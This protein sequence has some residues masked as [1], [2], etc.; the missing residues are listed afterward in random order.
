MNDNQYASNDQYNPD[1]QYASN[2]QYN[3]DNQYGS[4]DQYNP[5][6]QY[7]SNDQYNPNNQYDPNNQFYT[8]NR[9]APASALNNPTHS[10]T[11]APYGGDIY[12]KPGEGNDT[13]AMAIVSL[14]LG[15][16]SVLICC[17]YGVPSI[18]F[19][20]AGIIL[21]VLS[22]KDTGNTLSGLA[23]GGMICSII[24]LLLGIGVVM[25]MVAFPLM[26][27]YE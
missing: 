10:Q 4:N 2:D 7:G 5:N 9:H 15:I 21:A 3:P 13:S 27:L 14:V 22:R 17:C 18:I 24:G 6:S 20:I 1:N 11:Y 19:G 12:K 25:T 8:N 23:I 16:L 26:G